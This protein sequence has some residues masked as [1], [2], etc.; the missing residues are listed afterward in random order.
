MITKPITFILG[1]GASKPYGF[2]LGK[3]LKERIVALCRGYQPKQQLTKEFELM[4]LIGIDRDTI[5]PFAEQLHMSGSLSIDAFLEHRP[6]FAQ[7]GRFAIAH[8]LI[9]CE[10]VDNVFAAS[11]NWYAYLFNEMMKGVREPSALAANEVNFITYNYDRSLEFFLLTAIRNHFEGMALPQAVALLGNINIIHLHGQLGY[12]LPPGNSP[13]LRNYAPDL[14]LDAINAAMT[15]IKIIHEAT[16]DGNQAFAHAQALI[17]QARPVVLLGFGYHQTNIA[18][19]PALSE[20]SD[21]IGTVYDMT[22]A[23]IENIK[24]NTLKTLNTF[25]NAAH[26]NH[27]LDALAFLRDSGVLWRRW[28]AFMRQR[29]FLA[30]SGGVRAVLS[31]SMVS[32]GR[33]SDASER[34]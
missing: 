13:V 20:H 2:Y 5:I 25:G 16:N 8:E 7:I 10:I 28:G 33:R 1:A 34:I 14:S 4:S 31:N 24:T 21:V 32:R 18:R 9:R 3:E 23:E 6:S 26:P 11:S 30:S 22:E 19:F 27:T 15:G 17:K 29:I 12:L